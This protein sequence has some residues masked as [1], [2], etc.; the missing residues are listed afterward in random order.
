[1]IRFCTNTSHKTP[2]LSC[3]YMNDLK[4]YCVRPV[5]EYKVLKSILLNDRIRKKTFMQEVKRSFE[6]LND[7]LKKTKRWYKKG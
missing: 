6:K 3:L 1:M 5:L 2:Q 4:S 7:H